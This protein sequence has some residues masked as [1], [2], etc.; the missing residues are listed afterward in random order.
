LWAWVGKRSAFIS[1]RL[2]KLPD[3]LGQELWCLTN[4]S[5]PYKTEL[6]PEETCVAF[7]DE[8]SMIWLYKEQEKEW[9]R[10]DA[11]QDWFVVCPGLATRWPITLNNGESI[12]FIYDHEQTK[13]IWQKLL[14]PTVNSK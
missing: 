3:S 4:F 8:N 14:Q 10:A 2:Y 5:T 9:S 6:F 1:R 12:K 13:V 7:L 11:R